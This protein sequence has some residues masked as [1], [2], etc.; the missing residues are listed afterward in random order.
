VILL[1]V[2]PVR[3]IVPMSRAD[4]RSGDSLVRDEQHRTNYQRE[5]AAEQLSEGSAGQ[6]QQ[7]HRYREYRSQRAHRDYEQSRPTAPPNV[8]DAIGSPLC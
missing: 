1:V 5:R 3:S 4:L 2:V 6:H 7:R 8:C